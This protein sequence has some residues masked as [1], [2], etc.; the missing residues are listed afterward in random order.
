M[1]PDCPLGYDFTDKNLLI[2][3]LTHPSYINETVATEDYQRLEFLGDAILGFLLAELLYQNFPQLP[4]GDLSR[5]RA[6]L[7]DQ[8]RLAQL[9]KTAGLA[10]FIRLGKGEE[11]DNGRHKPSILADIFEAV[12]GAIYLDGGLSAVQ[13]AVKNIYLPLL[14]QAKSTTLSVLDPKSC[15]QERLAQKQLAP[16]YELSGEDGPPHKRNF[17]MTVLVDGAIWGIGSGYSKKAAQQEAARAA[18]L[19]L[20]GAGEG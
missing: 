18:L 7:V 10:S 12:I 6:S 19:K 4:E 13:V 3:A 17:T 14:D 11:R 9:T 15:L 5:L 1:M 20:G 8:T 2:A 16:H